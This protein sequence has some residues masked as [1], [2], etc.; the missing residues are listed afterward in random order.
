M[1]LLRR[2]QGSSKSKAEVII[3]FPTYTSRFVVEDLVK[4]SKYFQIDD[5][6]SS[7][8]QGTFKPVVDGRIKVPTSN[9]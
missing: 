6:T 4:N 3:K 7:R 1:A 2:V 9:L 8:I 5:Q